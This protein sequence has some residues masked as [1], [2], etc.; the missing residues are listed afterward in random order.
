MKTTIK[1]LAYTLLCSS[2]AQAQIKDSI[3]HQSVSLNYTIDMGSTGINNQMLYKLG[4][5]GYINPQL[6]QTNHNKLA[7]ASTLGSY[8]NIDATYSIQYKHPDTSRLRFN[9]ISLQR[10]SAQGFTF[11]RDLFG[12]LFQGNSP[13]LGRNLR[14]D[15]SHLQA[16]NFYNLQAGFQIPNKK[17]LSPD[18]F[19]IRAASAGLAL[20]TNLL[21]IK[22]QNGQI[23]TDTAG[24]FIIARLNMRSSSSNH[25]H[26][27]GIGPSFGLIASVN[28]N[29]TI[30]ISN[31]GFAYMF[32][33]QNRKP[34]GQLKD[35]R[36]DQVQ[37][38]S[39]QLNNTAWAQQQADTILEQLL[40][41]SVVTKPLKMLPIVIQMQNKISRRL[42][43]DVNYLAIKAY[44]PQITGYYKL[45]GKRSKL[46]LYGIGQLGGF[47]TYN[48][49]IQTAIAIHPKLFLSAQILGLEAIAL[50]TRTHGLGAHIGLLSNF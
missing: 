21:D 27:S 25:N 7:N 35:I 22:V 16:I 20:V 3:A 48:I 46:Q 9:S 28:R 49:G 38:T 50:P 6:I 4:L 37:I 40:P 33:T 24:D 23:Y 47:D 18:K 10:S 32:N 42:N 8:S 5:G 34:T 19:Q 45:T 43:V 15:N 11:S 13:Y 30:Q 26:I 31:L 17:N 41:P 2:V 1:L 44:I 39:A 14:L 36:I 12:L 29:T